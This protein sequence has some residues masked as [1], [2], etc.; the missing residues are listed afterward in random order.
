LSSSPRLGERSDRPDHR[1]HA[2]EEVVVPACYSAA[3]AISC[4]RGSLTWPD[5][6]VSLSPFGGKPSEPAQGFSHLHAPADAGDHHVDHGKGKVEVAASVNMLD[7]HT[8][9]RPG[10]S[11]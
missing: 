10:L 6:L 3:D 5:T 8:G 11:A 7:R 2:A 9:E 1:L 4:G